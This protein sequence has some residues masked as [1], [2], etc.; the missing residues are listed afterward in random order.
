MGN[1]FKKLGAAW[2]IL[3]VAFA[4]MVGVMFV[5]SVAAT[6]GDT[7]GTVTESGATTAVGNVAVTA[8]DPADGTEVANTTTDTSGNYSLHLA[9]GDYE[10]EFVKDGYTVKR[11][12]A[13]VSGATVVD[14]S[15][16]SSKELHNVTYDVTADD[17]ALYT[18]VQNTTDSVTV[19]YYSINNSSGAETLQKTV[20]LSAGPSE[21]VEDRYTIDSA[22]VSEYRVVVE[23]TAVEVL[24]VGIVGKISGGG[25]YFATSGNF[26]DWAFMG[27][28]LWALIVIIGLFGYAKS[29]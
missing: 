23:G 3:L 2:L 25:G 11:L 21:V 8:Y 7:T 22:N 18:E 16:D 5:G 17:D 20:H 26:F 14:A 12:S 1:M 27:F 15:L 29:Q 24:D 4:P 13:T 10:I 6:H 9:D 19:K 28:P